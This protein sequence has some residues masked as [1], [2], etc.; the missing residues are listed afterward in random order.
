LGAVEI[1]LVVNATGTLVA[2]KSLLGA[3]THHATCDGKTMTFRGGA[4]HEISWTFSP[5][6][7]GKTAAVTCQSMFTG[8]QSAPFQKQAN[9]EALVAQILNST[10]GKFPKAKPVPAKPGYVYSP[11]DPN[12][13]IRLLDVRGVSG[14]AKVKDPQSGKMFIVP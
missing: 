7:D 2:E 3:A 6:S 4:L 13:G 14:G 8:D 9:S 1:T 12:S 5:S 11:F 10:P